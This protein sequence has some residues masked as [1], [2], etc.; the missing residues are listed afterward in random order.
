[1]AVPDPHQ[2]PPLEEL[3]G[4]EA[5]AL[6]VERATAV[7]QMFAVT[8]RNASALAE[9]CVR[10]D[11]I[12]LALELA[13]ARVKV[14][15]VEHI[16]A[17]LDDR[18]RL[19]T[20]GSRTA[21]PRQQTLRALVDWSHELLS[22][23]ERVL[24]RRLAVFAG[25]FTLE[26]AEVVCA[27]EEID[28]A[29]M[30]DLF[31]HLVDKSLVVAEEQAGTVRYRLLETIRQYAED[32]LHEG[33]ETALVRTGHLGWCL[34]LAERTEPELAGPRQTWSLARLEEEHDNLRG[35]LW[36]A[37]DAGA[38][39]RAAAAGPP[40]AGRQPSTELD[41]AGLRLA[42]A[43]WRFWLMRGHLSE[44]RGWLE[45]LLARPG[46]GGVAGTASRA[47][48]LT[49][50]GELTYRQGDY[51]RAEAFFEESLALCKA[52]GDRQGLAQALNS[53]GNVATSQARYSQASSLHEQSLEVHR[54][55]GNLRSIAASL[56]NLADIAFSQGDYDRARTLYEEGLGLLRSVG[57]SRAIATL[58]SNLG[59]VASSQGDYPQA[60]ALH[61][62]SLALRRS[63]GDRVGLA[64]LLVDMGIVAF[65]QG[66]PTRAMTLYDEGLTL[67]RELDG[68]GLIAYALTNLGHAARALG[69]VARAAASYAE[70]LTLLRTV[71]DGFFLAGCLEGAAAAAHALGRLESSARLFAAT[72]ALRTAIAVPVPPPMQPIYDR[73]MAALR[74]AMGDEAFML[75]TVDGAAMSLE[76]AID[77]ALQALAAAGQPMVPAP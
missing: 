32:K 29:D 20:G 53:L 62:E 63:V 46:S 76:Q 47:K 3:T 65:Y 21:L 5:V 1:L 64:E 56:N 26:A 23:A 49:G 60:V 22:P 28:A 31:S 43:L 14:L 71:H 24:L 48:A 19:L 55:L 2:L 17:R 70:G 15:S 54:E 30:L 36:W 74:L 57:D 8:E 41:A 40:S 66:D 4:Y 18:F 67:A 6:F 58:L 68:K 39:E 51:E 44:G 13:A 7:Q 42:G 16:A 27:G 69:D 61:E 50:A 38:L 77:H 59:N 37:Y 25:G 33:H 11:G 9:M 72:A 45:R 52:L 75:A 73:D 12:P 10:L 35:A 34:A